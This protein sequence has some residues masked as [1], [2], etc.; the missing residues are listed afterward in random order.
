MPQNS[1]QRPLHCRIGCTKN[2]NEGACKPIPVHSCAED[3]CRMCPGNSSVSW[4]PAAARRKDIGHLQCP[5]CSL[6][7][8]KGDFRGHVLMCKDL[9]VPV[10][11]FGQAESLSFILCM[12]TFV[13]LKVLLTDAMS[14]NIHSRINCLLL[15]WYL[16][17]VRVYRDI[18]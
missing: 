16:W 6:S 10:R 17:R 7:C 1:R 3:S 8:N 15:Y 18:H 12:M 13:S 4:H 9:T 11:A 14:R 5:A 2:H